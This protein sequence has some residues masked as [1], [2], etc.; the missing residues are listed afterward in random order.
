VGHVAWLEEME[1]DFEDARQLIQ[2]AT[3]MNLEFDRS[4]H[5]VADVSRWLGLVESL[6]GDFVAAGQ[7]YR[8]G[9]DGLQ[10]MGAKPTL[11]YVAAETARMLY[12]QGLLED[13]E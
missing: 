4:L 13:S 10:E 7:A 8:R 6:A 2:E 12:I 5:N 11:A 3:A 1:G 9:A